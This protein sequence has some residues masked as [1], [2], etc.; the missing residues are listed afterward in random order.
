MEVDWLIMATISSDPKTSYIYD[1]PSDTWYPLAGIANTASNYIWSGTH[2][3]DNA[4]EFY[5]TLI[6]KVGLNN[7]LN[8]AARDAAITSPITNGTICFVRQDAAGAVIN[9]LQ[10]YYNGWVN[11]LSG[12]AATATTATTAGKLTT[13]RTING[14]SFDGSAN[15]KVPV[16]TYVDSSNT[17]VG[18][19]R[20][21]SKNSGTANPPT[22]SIDGQAPQTGDIY[23]GW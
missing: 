22:G 20:I 2:K 17:L 21:F 7:F 9:Q 12:N 13:A 19:R 3:F 11:L 14:V 6:S 4:T 10:Y 8:P 1:A 18:Y 23:F 15:V 5:S 16:V